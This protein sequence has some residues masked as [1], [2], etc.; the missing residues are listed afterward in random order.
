MAAGVDESA[1]FAPNSPR[2]PVGALCPAVAPGV[3]DEAGLFPPKSELPDAPAPNNEPPAGADKPLFPNSDPPAGAGAVDDVFENSEPPV[4]A[5]AVELAPPNKVLPPGALGVDDGFPNNPP[6]PA[7]FAAMND[8]K[9]DVQA[10]MLRNA[11]PNPPK[12]PPPPPPKAFVPVDPV[13]AAGVVDD[14]F[15]KR[16]I[17][18]VDPV[19]PG[20]GVVVLKDAKPPFKG[21]DMVKKKKNATKKPV[22]SDFEFKDDRARVQEFVCWCLFGTALASTRMTWL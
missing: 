16:F 11:P 6:P 22:K 15:P 5:G 2:P 14:A 19:P 8:M 13:F 17:E 20:S 10:L 1:G 3:A 12:R 21:S 18:G 4:G 7:G 9:N